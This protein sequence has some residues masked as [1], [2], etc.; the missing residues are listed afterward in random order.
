MKVVIDTNVF[1]SGLVNPNGYPG[2]IV[3]LLRSGALDVVVD[4]RILA[5][6]DD[7]RRRE[8][9]RA[10]FS[11][12]DGEDIIEFLRKDAY[13]TTSH[14]VILDMPDPGDVPFLEIALAES[15]PLIT[16]N[17]K[18]YPKDKRAGCQVLTPEEFLRT[19]FF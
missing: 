9:F 6:Y 12:Q 14:R 1:V 3:D 8:K 4:D 2:R 5:E 15:V 17:K 10:Y 13:R 18:H 7:V 16:G 19:F 11:K